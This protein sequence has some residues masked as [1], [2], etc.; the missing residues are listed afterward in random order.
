MK[1]LLHRTRVAR[2]STVVLKMLSFGVIGIG[3]TVID[4]GV[5]A[6]ADK[7]LELPLV[8]SNV[9][10]WLVA[11]SGSCVVNTTVTFRASRAASCGARITCASSFPALWERSRLPPRSWCCRTIAR[12]HGEADLYP[13]RLCGQFAMSHFIVFRPRVRLESPRQ[14]SAD[15]TEVVKNPNKNSTIRRSAGVFVL[16]TSVMS[17]MAWSHDVRGAGEK[18]RIGHRRRW[19][20]RLVSH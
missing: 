15:L 12:D 2:H 19:S 8:A 14:S 6:F 5:F 7:V 17:L 10:A 20:R 13:R 1:S 9:L 16:K 11:V 3:N 4:F 18:T